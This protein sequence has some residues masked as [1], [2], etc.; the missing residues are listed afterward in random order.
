MRRSRFTI[1][2]GAAA[3]AGLLVA[4]CGSD[5]SGSNDTTATTAASAT[6]AAGADTTAT[7]SGSGSFTVGSADFPESQLL[8]EIYAQALEAKGF[9]VDRKLNIGSREVY[10]KAIVDDEVQIL[11]EYTNSLLSFVLKQTDPN[12]TPTATDVASQLTELGTAL[13][14]D[15]QVLTPS[16]AEDKDTIVCTS[17]IATKYKLTN[18][19][20]LFAASSNITLGAP[21]EFEGR[22]PFGLAGF[23]EKGAK[24]K[25]FVPLKYGAIPDALSAGQIDCANIFSTDPA[26]STNGFVALEDD[27]NLVPNEAVV[28]LVR[29]AVGSDAAAVAALDAVSAALTTENLTRWWAS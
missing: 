11:P 28:P 25:E 24:F 18:L 13:P 12:A 20:T 17:D 9:T 6:T 29:T 23:E 14:A 15:L 10:Y 19:T 7:P 26:I 3:A 22:S 27:L 8:G 2:L 1:L 16:T 4:A 21:A 5:D